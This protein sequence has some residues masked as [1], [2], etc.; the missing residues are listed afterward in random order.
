MLTDDNFRLFV[1]PKFLDMLRLH[2]KTIMKL[3]SA[4]VIFL[5]LSSFVAVF[6]VATINNTYS[7]VENVTIVNPNDNPAPKPS[8]NGKITM[9]LVT[10]DQLLP[11]ES[12]LNPCQLVEM[13]ASICQIYWASQLLFSLHF[14]VWNLLVAVV[15]VSVARTQVAKARRLRSRKTSHLSDDQHSEV[16]SRAGA[17]CNPS[18]SSTACQ[19]RETSLKQ[20]GNLCCKTLGATKRWRNRTDMDN[21]GQLKELRLD[22]WRPHCWR[23]RR[24]KDP[25]HRGERKSTTSKSFLWIVFKLQCKDNS[26]RS[27]LFDGLEKCS[28]L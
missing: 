23:L 21:A 16:S 13:D 11:S 27:L 15:L 5:I 3:N 25:A 20:S 10:S 19:L 9:I 24:N 17:R 18:W 12:D 14:L 4:L 7:F 2:S 1:H 22:R 26:Y 8:Y 6:N 28:S